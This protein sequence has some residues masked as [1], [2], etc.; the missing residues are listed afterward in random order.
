MATFSGQDL[1]ERGCSSAVHFLQPHSHSLATWHSVIWLEQCDQMA[2]PLPTRLR[3]WS[4]YTVSPAI[5]LVILKTDILLTF[6]TG[7]WSL[8]IYKN[9]NNNFKRYER[10]SDFYFSTW[11][12]GEVYLQL[13]SVVRHAVLFCSKLSYIVMLF[14]ID[15]VDKKT[16]SH[17]TKIDQWFNR[18]SDMSPFLSL[19]YQRAAA[20]DNTDRRG[21]GQRFPQIESFKSIGIVSIS[22]QQNLLWF[23]VQK[24]YHIFQQDNRN[25]H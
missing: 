18:L 1:T 13:C 2:E 3:L 6:W 7:H 14:I 22:R 11:T 24:V 15:Q 12:G 20:D 23:T 10:F 25:A 5:E 19:W 4:A 17:V 9:L 8:Y 21:L 16:V